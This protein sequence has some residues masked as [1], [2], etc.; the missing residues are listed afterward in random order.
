MTHFDAHT[1]V[2]VGLG[3]AGRRHL[4]N[5]RTL[6]VER[7]ILVRTGRSTL[8]EV[9]EAPPGTVAVR[10]VEAAIERGPT[11][12]VISNPTSMHVEPAIAVA[13]AGCHLLIEK[14]VVHRLEDLSRLTEAVGRAGV[15]AAVG[16][17]FRF[18]PLIERLRSLIGG[19]RLGRVYAAR[20]VYREHLPAWHPWEDHRHGYA[21]REDLGGG[22]IRTLIHAP[23]IL[24]YLFGPIESASAAIARCPSLETSVPDDAA[25]LTLGFEAGVTDLITTDGR[26][27]GVKVGDE[28][29]HADAVILASGGFE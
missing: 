9:E 5:L 22:C 18:H 12:A 2:I 10:S 23:D 15:T 25:S 11:I 21:A 1:A 17:Q 6:G 13:E 19:E 20:A 28:T 16:C 3:S 14:P 26:V 7:F 29:L 24:R 8:G 4:R 27:T